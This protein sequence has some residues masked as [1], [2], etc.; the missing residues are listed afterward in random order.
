SYSRLNKFSEEVRI[1]KT[2]VS[3]AENNFQP[4]V[5]LGQALLKQA[6]QEKEED[7]VRKLQVEAIKSFRESLKLR[8]TFKPAFDELLNVTLL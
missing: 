7:K 1:L 3:K 4:R 8:P 5:L 6:L 2:W